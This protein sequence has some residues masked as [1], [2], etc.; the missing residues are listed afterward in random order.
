MKITN[1][2][3]GMFG[4]LLFASCAC[5]QKLEE[6]SPIVFKEY[7]YQKWVAGARGAGSGINFS[8]DVTS[9]PD[10][11][12]LRKLYFRGMKTEL[13]N[14]QR[15]PSVYTAYFKTAANRNPDRIMDA[16]S[17]AEYGNAVPEYKKVDMPFEI[18]DSEAILEYSE[19]G[20]IKYFKLTSVKERP[21]RLS[22][23]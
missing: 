23:R 15:T 7:Y 12:E 20:N 18:N 5:S 9:K 21:Y 10:N 3:L 14:K 17:S 8:I 13:Q 1:I 19:D 6:E 2:V 11:I 22:P 4:I 16:D